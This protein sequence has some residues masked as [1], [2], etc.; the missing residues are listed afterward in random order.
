MSNSRPNNT[1]KFGI[2]QPHIWK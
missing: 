1:V 2:M